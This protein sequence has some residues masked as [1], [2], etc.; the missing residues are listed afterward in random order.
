MF[1]NE[2]GFS[3]AE[4][5]IAISCLLIITVYI[6]PI[7][8]RMIHQLAITEREMTAE[9][10][11]Y[12]EVERYYVE[13]QFKDSLRNEDGDFYSIRWKSSV[14]FIKEACVTFEKVDLQGERCIRFE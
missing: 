2:K 6:C 8:N 13:R 14:G 12:E 9:R 3:I 4:G 10:M 7:M 1:K 5:L 11:L